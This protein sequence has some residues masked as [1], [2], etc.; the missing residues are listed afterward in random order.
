MP[1]TE[2]DHMHISA[3]SLIKQTTCSYME[4]E[5]ARRYRDAAPATLALLQG[6][7]A[8]LAGELAAAQARV[9][10]IQDV[11]S[12]RGEGARPRHCKGVRGC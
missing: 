4:E 1:G 5:L 7:C 12:L 9:A 8:A 2:L 10:A 6:R 11:A 3:A